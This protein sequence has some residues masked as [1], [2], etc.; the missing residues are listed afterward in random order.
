[1]KKFIYSLFAVLALSL[2]FVSC[3]D[4]DDDAVAPAGNPAEA[5]AAT[6]SGTWTQVLDGDTATAPGTLVI[7]PGDT[8]FVANVAV[9]CSDF[10]VDASEVANI[11]FAGNATSFVFNNAAGK[12]LGNFAGRVTDGKAS[13]MFSMEQRK[14]RK[15][16]TYNYT[17]DGVRQ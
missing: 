2:T 13:I 14:G 9:S 11:A 3:S 6:Y 4:D 16:Y 17:F 15:R 10:K 5:A 7:T 1:M 12:T 8:A